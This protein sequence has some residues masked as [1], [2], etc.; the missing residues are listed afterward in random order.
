[1]FVIVRESLIE[2]FGALSAKERS[3]ETKPP[4][5]VTPEA[6]A[7]DVAPWSMKSSANTTNNGLN[8]QSVWNADPATAS[9]EILPAS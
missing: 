4:K 7:A 5:R 6:T 3:A 2:T 1:L 9:L 8:L